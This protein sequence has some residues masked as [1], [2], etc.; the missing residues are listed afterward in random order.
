MLFIMYYLGIGSKVKSMLLLARR[1]SPQDIRRYPKGRFGPF[2]SPW[3]F[4]SFMHL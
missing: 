1:E 3:T 4:A 2:I